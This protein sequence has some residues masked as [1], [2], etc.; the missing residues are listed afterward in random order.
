[1]LDLKWGPII[2]AIILSDRIWNSIPPEY[3]EDI[4]RIGAEV[5]SEA[6]S[7]VLKWKMLWQ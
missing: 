7:L 4:V 2:G 6:R 5:E 1:M 3:H